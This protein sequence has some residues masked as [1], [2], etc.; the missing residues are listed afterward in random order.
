MRFN[1]K[2][3]L[4]GDVHKMPKHADYLSTTLLKCKKCMKK[5][6]QNSDEMML[7]FT[8]EHYNVMSTKLYFSKI[9]NL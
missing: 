6:R 8:E 2:R 5:C 9:T 7:Y 3:S 4:S 1:R